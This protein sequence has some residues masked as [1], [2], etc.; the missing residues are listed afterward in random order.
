MPL[1]IR[2]LMLVLYVN[3]TAL[4]FKYFPHPKLSDEGMSS[5]RL[6][7]LTREY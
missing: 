7:G 3:R 2:V 4:D 6:I 1:T 5:I